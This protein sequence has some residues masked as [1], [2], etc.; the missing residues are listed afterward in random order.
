MSVRRGMRSGRQYTRRGAVAAR[1]SRRRRRAMRAKLPFRGSRP[2]A[3]RS[4]ARRASPRRHRLGLVH[5]GIRGRRCRHLR[6]TRTRHRLHDGRG[7]PRLPRGRNRVHHDP[8]SPT[9][10]AATYPSPG[11]QYYALRGLGDFT[12]FLS[13]SAL[14]LD[15]DRHRALLGDVGGAR[16][17]LRAGAGKGLGFLGADP[18]L[19]P[20]WLGESLFI[21]VMLT[22]L[23][24]K[25]I[26]NRPS[27]TRSSA[28]IDIVTESSIIILGFVLAWKPEL[29][30]T[31][32]RTPSRR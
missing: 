12:G 17:F 5:V 7:P 23:N 20:V 26:R 28:G 8:D 21:I 29:S 19:Q 24:V 30:P 10:M 22:L 4:R 18:R 14:L 9:E 31:S 25:R 11:G 32:G 27:S 2:D 16:E 6:G 3:L 1:S 13:G 15:Y